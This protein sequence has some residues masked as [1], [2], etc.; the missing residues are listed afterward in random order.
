MCLVSD[1][2][3]G[4]LAA[5]RREWD[6]VPGYVHRYCA[7]HFFENFKKEKEHK[8]K[9]VLHKL[10]HDAIWENQKKSVGKK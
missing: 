10:A 4:I 1:R 3:Q 9:P 6:T 7:R 5:V 8:G 2:H